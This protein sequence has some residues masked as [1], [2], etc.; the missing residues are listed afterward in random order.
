MGRLKQAGANETA[1]IGESWEISGLDRQESIVAGGPYDGLRL[2]QLIDRLQARLLGQ[3]NYQKYGNRFPLLIKLIDSAQDLS[4]QVHPSDET[5]RQRGLANGKTEMW[6][7]V[8]ATPTA[9]LRTGFRHAVSPDEMKTMVADGSIC[10]ALAQYHVS[11]GDCFFLPA[12]RVH[13]I[14]AGCLIA[15]IQQTSDA[16]YRLYD[17]NR[18][19]AQGNMRPLHVDEALQCIDYQVY[20]DYQSHYILLPNRRIPLVRCSYFC[21]SLFHFSVSSVIDYSSLDSFVVWMI[22]DGEGTISFNDGCEQILKMGDTLL[23]PATIRKVSVNGNVSLL[24]IF[25]DIA[26]DSACF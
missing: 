14:G 2:S 17:Y 10:Q 25:P 12:G 4:I 26:T 7:I 16:T 3:A 5:A 24:E 13:S 21:T 8:R 19:D 9:T 20:K 1:H 6:Y 11:K 23:L 22:T 18:K 15:E